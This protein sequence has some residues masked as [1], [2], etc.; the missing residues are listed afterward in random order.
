MKRRNRKSDYATRLQDLNIVKAEVGEQEK[1]HLKPHDFD[2]K[3]TI[4]NSS[5]LRERLRQGLQQV[6]PDSVALQSCLAQVELTFL[7]TFT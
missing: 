5:S 7:N 2:P 3:S 4:T 1:R 6:F